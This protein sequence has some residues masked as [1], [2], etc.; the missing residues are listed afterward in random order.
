MSYVALIFFGFIVMLPKLS[1]WIALSLRPVADRLFGSEG[2]LAIDS[3]TRAPRRTSATVGALMAG[4]AFVFSTWATIQSSKEVVTRSFD[5]HI[6]YDLA[7]WGSSPIPEEIGLK[8]A[9]V[10]GIRHVDLVV[11]DTSGYRGQR[12]GLM[13]SDM[14]QWFKRPG[15]TLEQ[16]DFEKAREM[17][18]AGDGVLISDVFASRWSLRVGDSLTIA[19]PTA[20]LEKPVLGIVDAKAWFEGTVYFDRALYKEYWRND[21]AQWL[22]I[23]LEP[24]AD[25]DSTKSEVERVISGRQLLLVKTAAEVRS[26]GAE[27]V[28]VNIDQLFSFFYVQMFIATFVAIIGIVNTLVISV[29][30]RKR[31]IAII[32]A[33]GGTRRQIG[34]MVLLEA[35]IIGVVGLAAGIV[36]G[37]FDTYFMAH[38]AS[39]IFGGYSLPFHF[40]GAV[41]LL[42][43]PFVTVIALAAAWWPARL[44]AKTNVVTAIGS[45]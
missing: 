15:N 34:K 45:E 35:A 22:S 32:R 16:G 36:K 10:P 21:R 20:I 29:W 4:L 11:T 18:P 28:R 25:P 2:Q 19:A 12:A 41:I 39:G 40:P 17:V 42:S 13:A 23:E 44:A 33:V 24:G 3:I 8:V 43:V 31:E 27:A 7:I 6:N 9:S 37:V 26:V 5:R 14:A 1:Y 30:D 38:T